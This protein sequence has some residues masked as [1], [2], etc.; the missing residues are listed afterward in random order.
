MKRAAPDISV[1]IPCHNDE[2]HVL[3][4]AEAVIDQMESLG[5]SFDLIFIDNRSTDR[6]AALIRAL[7]AAEPRI[8]LIATTRNFGRIRSPAH[9]VLA[10]AGRAVIVM[11]ADFQDPP[12]LL[13]HFVRRWQAGAD[14]VLGVCEKKEGGRLRG[15]V[16]AIF[17]GLAAGPDVFSAIP[18]APRF[19]LYSRRA[20]EAIRALNDPEPFC[21][22]LLV[23]TGFALET[24]NYRGWAGRAKRHLFALPDWAVAG[25]TGSS[26]RLLRFSLYLGLAGALVAL[27]MMLGGL[28][29]FS[30][31]HPVAGWLIGAALQMQFALI[32]GFLG[33][34]GDHVRLISERTR[35]MPL[36]IESERVNF[37]GAC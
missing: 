26:K 36:V 31:G 17:H 8:R 11:G 37:P 14:I 30:T 21:R 13:P 32:F 10:A 19:G 5:A 2:G 18:K 7:C 33:L 12:D 4:L 35:R 24:V 25:W 3:A 15:V 6:T 28:G 22:G 1:V 16:G 23:E 20:V 29:A 34:M 27:L 9:A